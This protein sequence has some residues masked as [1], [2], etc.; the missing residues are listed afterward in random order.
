MKFKS[1]CKSYLKRAVGSALACGT[2][3]FVFL[4]RNSVAW[5][6]YQQYLQKLTENHSTGGI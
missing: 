2:E 4:Y 3:Q 5:L 1:W 6:R